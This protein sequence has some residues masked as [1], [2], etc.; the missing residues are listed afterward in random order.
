MDYLKTYKIIINTLSPLFI[1]SGESIGKK[2]YVFHKFNNKVLIPDLHKLYKGLK[3]LNLLREY[4]KYLLHDGRDLFAW[5]R[6]NNVDNKDYQQWM[7]YSLDSGDAVFE[8]RGKKEIQLFIKDS[9]GCPYI[10][11]SSLK[12]AI[13]TILLSDAILKNNN[14]Y[15]TVKRNIKNAR[16]NG[17][18]Y[19][20]NEVKN[21]ESQ[22][23]NTL[24]RKKD[25]PDDAVNDSLTG[26]RISD[27]KPLSVNN[28]VLCQKIDV[29]VDGSENKLNTLRE[30]LK[31]N[32][33]IEFVLTIDTQLCKYTVED[34]LDAVNNF[35]QCYY[36]AFLKAFRIPT[37]N[38][39]NLLYLGG[40]SGYVSKT[41]SYPLYGKDE[42]VKVVSDIIQNT[43]HPKV[44]KEHKHDRDVL[45]GVSPHMLKCTRYNNH[46]YEMGLCSFEI[47]EGK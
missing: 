14:Q 37:S 32:T 1:G 27:S 20:N 9:Y 2:E 38:M 45:L 42:G 22:G 47:I 15:S 4:E 39:K 23:F 25:K 34:I 30:S 40:G 41:I 18:R 24:E 46:L 17:K 31:P 10:P 5:F 29:A 44:K 12:G 11:G 36:G 21:I 33:N 8:D 6:A 3:E 43:L 26:I 19:L 35:Y 7:K 16:Y 28:L 13:R